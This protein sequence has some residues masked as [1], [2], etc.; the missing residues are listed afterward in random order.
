MSKW[1]T[2][3]ENIEVGQRV[4]YQAHDGSMTVPVK[5]LERPRSFVLPVAW[6]PAPE[7]YVP[8]PDWLPDGWK[9][10]GDQAGSVNLVD[11]DGILQTCVYEC[12]TSDSLRAQA[13]F[14]IACADA[15]EASK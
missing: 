11:G 1:R 10:E 2:D 6:M 12:E 3:F 4:L 15:R 14:L 13:A 9:V 8:R 7:P 5:P